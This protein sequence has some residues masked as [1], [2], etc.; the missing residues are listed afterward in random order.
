ME[1]KIGMLRTKVLSDWLAIDY[2]AFGKPV[3]A[4]K[5][6]INQASIKDWIEVKQN[7]LKEVYVL[8]SIFEDVSLKDAVELLETLQEARHAR[9]KKMAKTK[10]KRAK[11]EAKK[12]MKK[13]STKTKKMVKKVAKK[14]KEAYD[15][16]ADTAGKVA[17]KLAILEEELKELL[18]DNEI[19]PELLYAAGKI[20][21]ENPELT[22]L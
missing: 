15:L 19:V 8:M 5:D 11:K 6:T 22:G 21:I 12:K 13:K 4:V 16:D 17:L 2:I 1:V 18:G 7:A 14:L 3:L 10:A 9:A 20:Y